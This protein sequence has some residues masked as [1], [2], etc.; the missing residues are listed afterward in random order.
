MSA[1]FSENVNSATQ[2]FIMPTVYDQ[3][4]DSNVLVGMLL[5]PNK[6]KKFR[7]KTFDVPL[8]LTGS[9]SRGA[10]FR[11]TDTFKTDVEDY[12]KNMSFNPKWYYE[13]YNIIGTDIAINQ[14]NSE[15]EAFDL[16]QGL[17]EEAMSGLMDALG[18]HFYG[19][20]D[21]SSKDFSGLQ[22][23][24]S[25][26]G[27]IGGLSRT[28]YPVLKPGGSAGAGLDSSTTT[29]TLAAMRAVVDGLTSGS[30]KPN[31]AIGSEALY[32]IYEA[33]IPV[34][35]QLNV[36][37]LPQVTRDGLR[38]NQTSLT[39]TAGFNAL[40]FDGIPLVRDEKATADSLYFLN[41]NYLDFHAM[42]KPLTLPGWSNVQFNPSLI[43]GQYSENIMPGH[44]TPLMWSGFKEPT[45]Q[46]TEISQ[47]V[48]GGELVSK[49][50]K[51]QGGF[52]AITA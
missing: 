3:K 37:S 47:I 2:N 34:T 18:D 13:P 24:V 28:T 21:E 38:L 50:P 42:D 5:S 10:G 6:K 26:T 49:F 12:F 8:S 29:L 4:L 16:V 43:Q 41:M 39:G 9:K 23:I 45:N 22:H 48:I 32:A 35:N 7:G 15:E 52:T 51:Y 14:L 27:S 19:S 33:L 20:A 25:A 17:T 11:G 46:A 36:N 30:I 1:L 31:F 40:S 44:K